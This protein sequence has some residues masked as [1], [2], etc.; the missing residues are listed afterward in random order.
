MGGILRCIKNE[1]NL[2]QIENEINKTDPNSGFDEILNIIKQN[3]NAYIDIDQKGT[4]ENKHYADNFLEK[5]DT[6]RSNTFCI[7]SRTSSKI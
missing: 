7:E 4:K 2:D 1:Y 5:V 6:K 3:N